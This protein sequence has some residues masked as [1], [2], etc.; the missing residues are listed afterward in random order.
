MIQTCCR[1]TKIVATSGNSVPDNNVDSD[2]PR[3]REAADDGPKEEQSVDLR[4][5]L[6]RS[7]AKY[8]AHD[9]CFGRVDRRPTDG[10]AYLRRMRFAYVDCVMTHRQA[11]DHDAGE[12]SDA[13]GDT[14]F[15]GAAWCGRSRAVPRRGVVPAGC[16]TVIRMPR[17]LWPGWS[18]SGC[19]PASFR[20]RSGI[21][22]CNIHNIASQFSFAG[23][24]LCE[25]GDNTNRSGLVTRGVGNTRS[26]GLQGTGMATDK[27]ISVGWEAW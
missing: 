4:A 25:P 24:E 5:P 12:G 21:R 16:D 19:G 26:Q 15:S 11:G 17:E 7:P 13:S 6:L 3:C 14:H 27:G 23:A 1:A 9:W 18:R 8:N 2:Q 10:F 20:H 22:F